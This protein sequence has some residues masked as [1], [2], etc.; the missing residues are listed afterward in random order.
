MDSNQQSPQAA[1]LQTAANRR[2]RRTHLTGGN[3][4]IRTF[5]GWLTTNR[6]AAELYSPCRFAGTRTLNSRIKS[7]VHLPLSYEPISF[8]RLN[9][10][11]TCTASSEVKHSDPL[12]HKPLLLPEQDLNLYLRGQNPVC[13]HCTIRQ[14][15]EG[16][17]R[18]C[19]LSIPGGVSDQPEYFYVLKASPR[20]QRGK[21]YSSFRIYLFDPLIG[22][23]F[24][25]KGRTIQTGFHSFRFTHK[26]TPAIC[27]SLHIHIGYAMCAY[28]PVVWI[29]RIY[30]A[31]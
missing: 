6:S 21:L 31:L 24:P 29:D 15:I 2:L 1:V 26:K 8:C 18:T 28:S 7:P 22:F 20:H 9:R 27:R 17:T 12:N 14:C 16:R 4:M 13:S 10:I 30:S 5:I 25:G 3:R 19:S 23:G 11:R